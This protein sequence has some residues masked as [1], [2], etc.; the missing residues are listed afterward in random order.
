MLTVLT[1]LT[2]IAT[3][4]VVLVL[5]YYLIAILITVRAVGGTKSSDL[6]QLAGGLEAIQQQTAP[7][8]DDMRTI[9]GALVQ[10]L[11]TLRVVDDHLTATARALG[12]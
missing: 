8:P 1:I 4:I 9:N 11:E 10:L 5:A 7:L 3:A 6:G 12:L 2:I